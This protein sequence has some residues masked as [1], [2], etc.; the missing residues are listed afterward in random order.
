M[1]CQVMSRDK[2]H[3]CFEIAVGKFI[4]LARCK[5]VEQMKE[6]VFKYNDPFQGDT[7]CNFWQDL[8]SCAISGIFRDQ[9]TTVS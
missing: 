2:L 9:F 3:C 7:P 4:V 8:S 6:V 1:T 5:T